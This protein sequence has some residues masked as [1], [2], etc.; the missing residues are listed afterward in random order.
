MLPKQLVMLVDK[1]LMSLESG[2]WKPPHVPPGQPPEDWL[3]K[4][5][6]VMG[7]LD[8]P[9]RLMEYD[10][11]YSGGKGTGKTTALI[12]QMIS[13]LD[14][15]IASGRP[16]NMHCYTPKPDDFHP[17][18]KA[19]YESTDISVRT[20]NPFIRDSWAWDG[21]AAMTCLPK[22][23]ELAAAVIKDDG[24]EQNP[25]FKKTAQL[26]FRGVV[27]S[28]SFT[29]PGLWTMR[30]VV[31]I[32]RDVELTR[33][34]LARCPHTAPLL[35]LL[36][37]EQGTTAAN[38]YATNLTELKGLELTA[39]LIDSTPDDRRFTAA[40][41][42]NTPGV[43]WVWG[44]DPRYNTTIEPWNAVQLELIGHELLI[45]GNIG[46]DT[47]LYIDE[48]PQLSAGGASKL[49]IIKKLLE[50]GRSSRV[51]TTLAVQTPSQVFALHGKED[52]ETLLAQC[53]NAVVFGH[54][55]G[56]G[57]EYWSRR[58]GKERGFET[59]RSSSRQ[60]GGTGGTNPST[61]WSK[62]E[63]VSRERFDLDRVTSSDIGDLPV[64]S[65]EF[66]MFGYASL[67][68]SRR[69]D[70]VTGFPQALKWRFHLDPD[71]IRRNVPRPGDFVSYAKSLKP[72]ESY[73]LAPFEPWERQFLRLATPG[74]SRPA[75]KTPTNRRQSR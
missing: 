72:E 8:V 31:L 26:L 20:T 23:D 45:R 1:Y 73:V 65:Y 74:S 13:H 16:F 30:H 15:L 10:T 66:G 40:E 25:F 61:N 27:Q 33:L 37:S 21:A 55:D 60:V 38:I 54:K 48:F 57:Q 6:V 34:V 12:V 49:P 11:V 51:R 39:S 69:L 22:M 56:P 46:I 32:L 24:R 4:N 71:W 43:V 59:K 2:G 70:P 47:L 62:S 52:G 67:P 36:S 5:S 50:Y 58:F 42:A 53:H 63:N 9:I 29:H 68:L 35:G 3:L 64:G 41:A 75:P 28:L 17:N 19:R 7:G 14:A 44:S 18:L